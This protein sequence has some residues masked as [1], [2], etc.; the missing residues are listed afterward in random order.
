MISQFKLS[1]L[2]SGD[3]MLGSKLYNVGKAPDNMLQWF[4]AHGTQM[5]VNLT[6]WF[7]LSRVDYAVPSV[8]QNPSSCICDGPKQR[9]RRSLEVL[10]PNPVTQAFTTQPNGLGVFVPSPRLLA[11]VPRRLSHVAALKFY[12]VHTCQA[13]AHLVHQSVP[14][15]L[16]ARQASQRASDVPP[17]S[18]HHHG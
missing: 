6:H 2:G 7:S 4:A 18:Q 9:K 13:L 15:A 3:P 12:H 5:T 10:C 17:Y 14:T 16:E 1:E 8:L 11:R